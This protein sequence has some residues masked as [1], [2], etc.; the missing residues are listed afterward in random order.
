MFH[1][2]K[3]IQARPTT[4][5]AK[6]NLFNILENRIEFEETEAL[7]LFSGTGNISFELVSRGC[8]QVT[9]VEKV[10]NHIRFIRKVMN[11]LQIKNLKVIKKDV[12]QFLKKPSG[13]YDLIFADPPYQMKGIEEIPGII[14]RQGL[15]KK[16]GWLILEH[17]G[18][19]KGYDDTYLSEQR[20]YGTVHF[21]FFAWPSEKH[22]SS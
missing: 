13:P 11:D 15:L 6:E 9:A 8:H 21:S 20:K 14:F 12:F 10:F 4:D 3:N 18:H 16:D 5:F 22:A 19:L 17:S 1:P 7:D 2:P